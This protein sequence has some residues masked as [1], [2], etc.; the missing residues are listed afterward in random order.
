MRGS[1][2]T[3]MTQQSQH[4]SRERHGSRLQSDQ[5][6]K[7]SQQKQSREYHRMK[8]SSTNQQLHQNQERSMHVPGS[9]KFS[10]KQ[11]PLS[12]MGEKTQENLYKEIEESKELQLKEPDR[13]KLTS[14]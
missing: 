8:S 6:N 10:K 7:H 3:S 2:Q 11:K 14:M 12:Q 4:L 9:S 5:G 13:E 1:R